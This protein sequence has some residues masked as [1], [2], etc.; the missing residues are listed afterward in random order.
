MPIHSIGNG[1]HNRGLIMKMPSLLFI[2]LSYAPLASS[3]SSTRVHR[4][5][6]QLVLNYGPKGHPYDAHSSVLP[7]TRQLQADDGASSILIFDPSQRYPVKKPSA[8][9]T[10][11]PSVSPST[12]APTFIA[13]DSSL[14]EPL[15]IKVDTRRLQSI[16][17]TTTTTYNNSPIQQQQSQLFI[18]HLIEAANKAAE[19]WSRHLSTIP[20]A[21]SIQITKD[22]CPLAFDLHNDNDDDDGVFTYENGDLIL[23]LFVDEGPCM[24]EDPPIAFSD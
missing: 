7:A 5:T 4:N 2:M 9:P 18:T 17:T 19:F 1:L 22:Q 14:Y 24:G 10:I 11:A 15:R 20:V 16:T 3:T 12:V 6:N 13:Y 8:S 23:Y 21:S